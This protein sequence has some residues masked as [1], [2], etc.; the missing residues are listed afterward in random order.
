MS[1]PSHKALPGQGTPV[2]LPTGGIE[3]LFELKNKGLTP[4]SE[5]VLAR[6]NSPVSLPFMRR[7]EVIVAYE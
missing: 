7:N 1:L 5:P 4:I 6:Y 3:V 2:P